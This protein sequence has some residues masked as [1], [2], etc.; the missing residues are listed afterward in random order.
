[1]TIAGCRE[2]DRGAERDADHH[3]GHQEQQAL[4]EHDERE[5][6]GAAGRAGDS[7]PKMTLQA[8]QTANAAHR[9]HD[10]GSELGRQDP[11][12]GRGRA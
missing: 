4:G 1:M 7:S 12:R 6:P 8:R 9:E 11:A 10:R 2:H 5:A 3:G